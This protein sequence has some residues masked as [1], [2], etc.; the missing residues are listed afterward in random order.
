MFRAQA[1]NT[2][3]DVA[4]PIDCAVAAR[5]AIRCAKPSQ[6]GRKQLM[7]RAVSAQHQV[8]IANESDQVN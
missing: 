1:T 3:D 7:A 8:G 4:G 6:D 2:A 5:E